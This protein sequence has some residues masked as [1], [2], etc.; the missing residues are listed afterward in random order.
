[1]RVISLARAVILLLGAT[2]VACTRANAAPEKG[3]IEERLAKLESRQEK[4]V[5]ELAALRAR[6]GGA[7]RSELS[8]PLPEAP[9]AIADLP[10]L[11]TA[12]RW[13][14]IEYSDFQ[15]Q[16]CQKHFA[17]TFPQIERDYIQTGKLRYVFH[18]LPIQGAEA[19]AA[20]EASACAQRQGRFWELHH[21]LFENPRGLGPDRLAT[22]A[23]AIGLNMPAYQ[24][25]ITN[26]AK[27]VVRR[28]MDAAEGL[29]IPGTPAFMIGELQEDGSVQ[30]RKRIQG[31]QPY[32]VFQRMLD[33]ILSGS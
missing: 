28:Q 13:T 30:V 29:A 10:S 23:K 33:Q 17:D 3:S 20:A 22:D 1:M 32:Q 19:V 21:K 9:I 14:L 5:T 25:C 24:A 31:A 18:H 27:E 2:I 11:G 12:R 16:F 8:L 6:V 15:C 7:T 4:L 26:V